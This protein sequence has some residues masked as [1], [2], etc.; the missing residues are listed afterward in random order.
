MLTIK[1]PQ[2]HLFWCWWWQIK[3]TNRYK[4]FRWGVFHHKPPE[5]ISAPSLWTLME[6]WKMFSLFLFWSWLLC[7]SKFQTVAKWGW[8]LVTVKTITY[9]PPHVRTY[10]K[11]PSCYNI[12]SFSYKTNYK[13]LKFTLEALAAL[14]ESSSWR[15]V[16]INFDNLVM[17]L[18]LPSSLQRV[19]HD[20]SP[21]LPDPSLR[22]QPMLDSSCQSAVTLSVRIQCVMGKRHISTQSQKV[23][24]RESKACSI[25]ITQCTAES[26]PLQ[27]LTACHSRAGPRHFGALGEIRIWGPQ[28]APGI[29]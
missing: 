25:L 19:I 22:I 12:N 2:K 3:G 28:T 9:M 16:F 17:D 29:S 15:C 4:M 13:V 10:I 5:H 7:R 24:S 6:G 14:S 26:L 18:H 23:K 21:L 11:S 8:D 1:T 27:L 20:T